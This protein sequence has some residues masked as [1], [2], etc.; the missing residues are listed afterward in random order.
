MKR[1]TIVCLV[2]L[3]VAMPA[4]SYDGTASMLHQALIMDFKFQ[5]LPQESCCGFSVYK[6]PGTVLVIHAAPDGTIISGAT[7]L[8]HD[9]T[10]S[11]PWILSIAAIYVALQVQMNKLDNVLNHNIMR[12]KAIYLFDVLKHNL[13]TPNTSFVFDDVRFVTKND[14]GHFVVSLAPMLR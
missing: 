2:L 7:A 3:A 11:E 13:K 12:R 9:Y 10:H 1:L 5:W 4:L 14:S 8:A 6:A